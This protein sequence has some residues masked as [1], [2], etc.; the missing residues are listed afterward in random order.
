[1]TEKRWTLCTKVGGRTKKWCQYKS[2]ER[3]KVHAASN[4]EG[5]FIALYPANPVRLAKLGGRRSCEQMVKV[6]L[7]QYE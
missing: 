2:E 5:W 4:G 6:G 1:M 3:A 7:P